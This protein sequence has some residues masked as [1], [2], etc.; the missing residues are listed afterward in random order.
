MS[1]KEQELSEALKHFRDLLT[2]YPDSNDNFFHFQSFIRK[3]LRVKTDK[4]T[5]PTSEIMAVIKY[6]RPTIFR[7]IKG[8]ANKDNTLYF[9]THI[10]MDYDRAQE[11]LNDLIEII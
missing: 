10:D 7:T 8:V 2:K 1:Y 3:F 6:E 4:V 9:L 11:R 5:L